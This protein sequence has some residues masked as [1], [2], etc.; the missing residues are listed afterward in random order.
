M[1]DIE[2]IQC[3]EEGYH[4][5]VKYEAWRVAQINYA[6]RF[7]EIN[8]EKLE[9]HLETDEVFILT[10]G[11]AFLITAGDEDSPTEFI[12]TIM[13]KN[14]VYNVKKK[15]WHYIFVSKDAKVFLV[16]NDSTSPKNTEYFEIV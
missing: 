10:E 8:F 15:S 11:E 9:R 13:E 12:K 5:L 6:E 2:I 4:P 1:K 7:D 14:V 3:C 16:E